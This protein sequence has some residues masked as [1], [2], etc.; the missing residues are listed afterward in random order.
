MTFD[1]SSERCKIE[2]VIVTERYCRDVGRWEKMR[3]FWYPEATETS[4]KITWFSG[5]V[6]DYI[7]GSRTLSDE[8][9]FINVK[10]LINPVDVTS[11]SSLPRILIASLR[12]QGNV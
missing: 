6:D 8:A 4:V 1:Y 12:R 3:S 10:Y 5:T 11:L 7:E 9:G 2:H